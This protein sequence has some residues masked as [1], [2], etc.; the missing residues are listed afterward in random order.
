VGFTVFSHGVMAALLNM[1]C[2][3]VTLC[4]EAC[5]VKQHESSDL[6]MT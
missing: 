3:A 6:C 1:H 4:L 2:Y 5:V